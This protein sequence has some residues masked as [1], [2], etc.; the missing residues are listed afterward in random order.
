[1]QI[2]I[3][4]GKGGTGKTTVAVNLA[5]TLAHSDD[6]PGPVQLLDCD[7]EE[8]NDHLFTEPRFA[9]SAPV[10]VLKPV[11]DPAPC[12]GC[13]ECARAC[14]FNAMAVVKGKVIIFPELCHACGV[15]TEVCPEN[16][17]SEH[18]APSARFSTVGV[19]TAVTSSGTA[20]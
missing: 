13:G 18:P 16:A 8:P 17:I 12:T 7:V 3:A 6:V 14:R 15:C 19:E 20:S 5:W 4:S 2:T 10:E 9:E 11:W 1:M